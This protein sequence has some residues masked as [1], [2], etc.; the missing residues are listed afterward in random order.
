MSVWAQ[1][2]LITVL[3]GLVFAVSHLGMQTKRIADWVHG[4]K[5]LK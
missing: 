5:E 4:V 3:V 1:V 2:F